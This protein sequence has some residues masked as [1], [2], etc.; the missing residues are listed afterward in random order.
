MGPV[1]GARSA[2][3]S[4][5]DHVVGARPSPWRASLED[6][7][8]ARSPLRRAPPLAPA[9]RKSS[10]TDV[11]DAPTSEPV[12]AL[13]A[14]AVGRGPRPL[15]LRL[16]DPRR[17][18]L[19]PR[20]AQHHL[21]VPDPGDDPPPSPSPATTSSGRPRPAPARRSASGSRSSTGSS[22]P[23]RRR[24]RE[25]PPRGQAAGPGRRPDARARRAGLQRPRARQGA[26]RGIRVLTVYGGRA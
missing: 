19:G 4:A 22:F 2:R 3:T 6:L 7:R 10:M 17:H 25:P 18:R 20:E 13:D 16:P 5:S 11:T 15:L 26:D 23:A 24:L 14:P 9:D 1:H 8:S 12:E 21:A